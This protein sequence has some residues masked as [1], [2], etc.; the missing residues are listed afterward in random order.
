MTV[1]ITSER[2]IQLRDR[3][4]ERDPFY[5]AAPCWFVRIWYQL[6]PETI[7]TNDVPQEK[8]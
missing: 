7:N 4:Q 5:Y 2:D 1:R 3:I 6:P 8:I